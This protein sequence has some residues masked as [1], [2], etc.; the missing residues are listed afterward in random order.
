VIRRLATVA[1]ILLAALTASAL[2]PVQLTDGGPRQLRRVGS[3][4]YFSRGYQELW[5]SDGTPAGTVLIAAVGGEIENLT[6]VD[7]MAFFSV[8]G[9]QLWRSDGTAAGTILLRQFHF[10]NNWKVLDQFIAYHGML[11]FAGD[12]DPTGI[13]LWRSDGTVQGTTIVRDINPQPAVPNDYW[14]R[15]GWSWPFHIVVMNDRLYFKADDGTNGAELWTSDGTEVGTYMVR[16]IQPGTGGSWPYRLAVLGGVVLFRADDGVKGGELWKSDGTAGGTMLVKDIRPGDAWTSSDLDYVTAA[17]GLVFFAAN[18]GVTGRELWKSDGTTSG[19]QLVK[20]IKPGSGGS[21]PMYLYGAMGLLFC[22]ADGAASSELWVSDG[23]TGGTTKLNIGSGGGGPYNFTATTEAVYFNAYHPVLNRELWRTNGTQAGTKFVADIE[24]SN[25]YDGP[26]WIATPGGTKVVFEEYDRLWILN[27]CAQPV[28]ISAPPTSCAGSLQQASIATYGDYASYAWT[29]TNATI[30]GAANGPSVQFRATG[31]GP[32]TL[33]LV[34]TQSDGCVGNGST[35]I[36]LG[37]LAAPNVQVSYDTICPLGSASAWVTETHPSYS[38]TVTNAINVTG[39]GTSSIQFDHQP[40]AGDITVSLTVGEG[41][42]AVTT[43]RTIAVRETVVPIVHV[44]PAALC[45]NAT[46]TLTIDNYASFDS[47]SFSITNGTLLS[48]GATTTFSADGGGNVQIT[49]QTDDDSCIQQTQVTVPLGTPPN[50]PTITASGP[51]TFCEGGSVTLTANVSGGTAPYSYQWY[52]VGQPIAGATSQTYVAAPP[53]NDY[54]YVAVSDAAGCVSTTSD[55]TVITVN[56]NPTAT[57]TA[58]S[59]MCVGANGSASAPDAGPGST[60][61]WTITGGTITSTMAGG[62]VVFFTA[63]ASGQV[64]LNVTVTTAAGCSASDSETIAINAL[65]PA[66]VSASGPTTFCAGGSVTLTAPAGY[67]Y[68]WSNNATTQAITVSASGSYSVTVTNASSCSTTSAATVVTV[69]ANPTATIT[70]S[71]PTTF[72]A[73]GSV[74]L[75]AP[76]GYTYLWSNNATTQSIVVSASGSYSVTVTNASSCSTTSAPTS[77]T[78]NPLPP[79]TITPSGPTTFCPGGSVTLTAPA[80]YTYLWS[81]NATTQSIIVSASGSY[82]VT[83]TANSCSSTS[84]PTT[85]TVTAPT[86][87]TAQPQNVTMRRSETRVLSV[88]ATGTPTLQYQWYEG[89][90]GDISRPVGTGGSQLTIGPYAK[91][92]TYHYW[93]RVTSST[94]GGPVNS[95]TATVTVNN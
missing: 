67:T 68:L 87:I 83:V 31:A 6:D 34:A 21:S 15:A 47:V 18:D 17:N 43:T 5:K 37:A 82:S 1:T 55:A 81:N 45:A 61:N 92:G 60:Y 19:T 27:G 63:G 49:I 80:G 36:P 74:T 24:P 78:V 26:R 40:N 28:Q 48:T 20:D 89:M 23:T 52:H 66:T 33:S 90:S 30:E 84:A 25:Y 70:P 91:K 39:L 73:G 4:I 65:P 58:P 54:Y 79:A 77:V 69:N 42:C 95:T 50:K 88:T 62:S 9:N 75:T 72:C 71:G 16:D 86:A 10:G 2:T 64:A 32:V 7:G 93:V 57:I 12:D 85:V 3:E 35:T 14:S 56:A 53:G 44:T 8:N 76:A 46:G 38:W 94:C 29:A 41:S 51:T 11:F 13:E 22:M 59:A